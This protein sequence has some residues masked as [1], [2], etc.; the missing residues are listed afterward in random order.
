MEQHRV[1]MNL[2]TRAIWCCACSCLIDDGET[3]PRTGIVICDQ[4]RDALNSPDGAEAEESR[5]EAQE[6]KEEIRYQTLFGNPEGALASIADSQIH[7]NLRRRQSWSRQSRQYLLS[8][9]ELASAS[10]QSLCSCLSA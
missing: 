10:V 3:Q 9:L 6:Q 7:T 5:G 4:I 2:K 8:Q 1:C